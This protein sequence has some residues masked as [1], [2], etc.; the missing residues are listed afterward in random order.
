VDPRFNRTSSIADVYARIRP[1]SDIAF[2]NAMIN[3]ILQNRLYDE[4]YVKLN[5]NALYLGKDDFEFEDGLFTSFHD[6]EHKYDTASWGYRLAAD[7][8]PA[9]SKSLDNPR[10][11]FAK[12][13]KFYSRYTLQVG[14]EISGVPA[15]QIRLIAPSVNS[16]P[17]VKYPRTKDRHP[18]GKAAEFPYVLMTSSMA[19]HWCGG[20]TTRNIACLNELVP[21]PVVEIREKLAR[22]LK[23]RTGDHVQVRS[24]RGAVMVKAVVTKRMQALSINGKEVATVWMPYNWGF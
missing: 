14:S 21:E 19:E 18:V 16:N 24:A 7:K 20:S 9:K 22:Q 11:V 12:L 1:G 17:C 13:K 5:T 15:D 6:A 8:T 4:K 10:C 3:Y 23:V 2:L